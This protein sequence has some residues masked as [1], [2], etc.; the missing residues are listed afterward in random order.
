MSYEQKI[1]QD[2]PRLKGRYFKA[3]QRRRHPGHSGSARAWHSRNHHLQLAHQRRFRQPILVRVFKNPETKQGALGIGGRINPPPLCRSKK[4]L[5]D[6]SPIAISKAAL[7]RSLGRSRQFLYYVSKKEIKDWRLKIKIEEVL[8]QHPAYGSRPIALALEL[9]RKGVRR[10]MRKFGIRSRR[11][12]GKK[13]RQKKKIEVVYPNLLQ[14]TFPQSTN[15]IWAADFTEF[16]YQ[17]KK[18]YLA[19][20]IDLF[21]R[22]IVGATVSIRKGAQ[23]TLQALYAALMKRQ[24]P[25]IFHSD[26]GKDYNAQV[27]KEVLTNLN[28]QIS[29]SHPGCPWENGYQESFYDKFQIDLGDPNRFSYLGELVAEIYR[30]IWIYNHTRI[31]SALKMPPIIFA[32][33]LKTAALAA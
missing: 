7:A 25:V 22:E 26:N 24:P 18:V 3:S 10:V 33:K 14:S 8:R 17:A 4:D 27:F 20:V 28:I 19:T 30:T 32:Q 6:N 31:H 12:R 15:H 23:L 29:R 5:K 13:W 21:T 11:G 1:P 2:Q 16:N 9:N